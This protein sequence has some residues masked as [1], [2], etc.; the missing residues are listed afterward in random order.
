MYRLNDNSN[1]YGKYSKGFRTPSWE[2]FNSSHINVYNRGF[3]W[4]SYSTLG[5]PN[6]KS[7]TSDNY[8][9]GIKSVNNKFDYSIAG[10]YQKFENF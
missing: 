8:E 4:Q 9:I 6:L 10:F 5:N 1:I 7:E 3:G 2:E